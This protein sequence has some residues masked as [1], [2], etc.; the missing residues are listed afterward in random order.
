MN[1]KNFR[2]YLVS[3]GFVVESQLP[4][5]IRW[6]EAFL[7]FCKRSA[8]T[9]GPVDIVAS[10]NPKETK[11]VTSNPQ[12]VCTRLMIYGVLPLLTLFSRSIPRC[13]SYARW[14]PEFIE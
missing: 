9:S 3:K 8:D 12:F 11:G 10:W 6:V 4:Y 7:H 2:N 5:Y 13:F 14:K 1:L